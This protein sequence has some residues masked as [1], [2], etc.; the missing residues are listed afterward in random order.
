MVKH[1]IKMHQSQL[2]GFF[3][4]TSNKKKKK[5]TNKQTQ[6]V[7]SSNGKNQKVAIASVDLEGLVRIVVKNSRQFVKVKNYP[8]NWSVSE[9][10]CVQCQSSLYSTTD[11]EIQKIF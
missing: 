5:Q 6:G 8:K 4:S 9:A 3:F 10:A 7:F 2:L 1:I 11:N